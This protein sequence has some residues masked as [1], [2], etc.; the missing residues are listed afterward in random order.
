VNWQHFQA[1]LALRWRLWLN[2]MKKGGTLQAILLGIL[3]VFGVF[4]C[5]FLVIIAFVMGMGMGQFKPL[6]M[7]G[8]WDGFVILFLLIWLAGVMADLQRSEGLALD[9]LLHMP[10]SLTG[11]FL[12]NY[13]TSLI[14]IRMAI[15]LPVLT[16]LT[17]GLVYSR[18]PAMFILIPLLAAFLLMVTAITYQFQGWLAYLMA[19]KRRRRLIVVSVTATF[20][21]IGQLPN[22]LG[23]FFGRNAQEN[24][25][26]IQ[27]FETRTEPAD[28]GKLPT[29]D[30]QILRQKQYQREIEAMTNDPFHLNRLGPSMQLANVVLPPGWLPL[31]AM[32]LAEGSVIPALLGILGMTVLGSVSLWRSYKVTLKVYTGQSSSRKQP[33]TQI[34]S[35][36]VPSLIASPASST[37]TFTP[38]AIVSSPPTILEKKLPGLP[39]HASAIALAGMRSFWRDPQVILMILTPIIMALLFGGAILRNRAGISDTFRPL[40]VFGAMVMVLGAH[41]QMM[42]NQFGFDRNGFRVYVLSPA[43]RKDI[44]FGKNI[45]LAPNIL[46]L[47][48]ILAII[49]QLVIP[50]RFDLFLAVIPQ[51]ISMFLVFCLLCNCMSIL[52]PAALAT[53]SFRR[54]HYRGFAVLYQIGFIFAFPLSQAPM[55]LPYGIE[56]ILEDLGGIKGVPICLLLS[57][58]E[59]VGVVYLYRV[60]LDLEGK[61]LQNREKRILEIVAAKAE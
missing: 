46:G 9:K 34:K 50:M 49:L 12:M 6:H 33:A 23:N 30:Q 14:G 60:V 11:A 36:A 29:I 59:L 20:I 41:S 40:V 16:G 37:I 25:S 3:A 55:L 52:A 53:G 31:G 51:G 44:L 57:I 8:I 24:V 5:G 27:Q 32:G 1:I 15:V 10:V 61:W 28:N 7:L 39:E 18:G 22:I 13:L 17:M 43:M 48:T 38:V 19:N 35:K 47:A 2:Q 26:R 42:S 4:F 21:L 56:K 45:T 54:S 58:L